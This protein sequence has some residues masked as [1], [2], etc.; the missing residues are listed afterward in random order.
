MPSLQQII[1]ALFSLMIIQSCKTAGEF[2]ETKNDPPEL[3]QLEALFESK[4]PIPVLYL[5]SYHMNNP[6][7]DAFNLEADDVLANKRQKEIREVIELLK[8]FKPTKVAIEAGWGDSTITARY[9]A[10]LQGNL[11]LNRTEREQIG[12]RLAKELGH[13]TIYPIDVK[14]AMQDAEVGALIQSNPS[15]FGPYMAGLEAAGNGVMEVMGKWLENGTVREML[16]NMNHPTVEKIAHEF[17]FQSFVP[18]TQDENYAGPDMVNTWYQRNIRIF[19]NLHKV[20][21]S[22]EDRVFVIYGQGH[23]PLLKHFTEASPYFKNEDVRP[24]LEK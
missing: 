21:D 6:G 20:A 17:Y 12:F 18:I 22:P 19:S 23:I 5:G 16:Y 7:A 13:K 2:A 10:F 8:A 14:M 9:Q 4:T 3:Q 15:Q 24:Y 1:L 11:D